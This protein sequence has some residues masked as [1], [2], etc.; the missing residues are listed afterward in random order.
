M[1]SAESA[2][3]NHVV[4]SG[5]RSGDERL[6]DLSQIPKTHNEGSKG[7]RDPLPALH[8]PYF[9][10]LAYDLEFNS[11]KG[12]SL[13]EG[14]EGMNKAFACG[15]GENQS[16][17]LGIPALVYPREAIRRPGSLVA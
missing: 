11:L 14:V 16:K 5:C 8:F 2:F 7:I 10:L 13:L 4:N 17:G 15:G 6:T 3:W 1:I 9:L 12:S